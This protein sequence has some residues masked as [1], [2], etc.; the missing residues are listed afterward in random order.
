M[1]KRNANHA[2][3]GEVHM[4]DANEMCK[5]DGSRNEKVW[6]FFYLDIETIR[7]MT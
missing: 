6:I 5:S 3:K 2:C 4:T 1:Q 7:I